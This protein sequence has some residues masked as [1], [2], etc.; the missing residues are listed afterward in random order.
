MPKDGKDKIEIIIKNPLS[1]TN[2]MFCDCNKLTS[3][4]LSNINTNNVQD[5]SRMFYNCSSLIS[6]NLS[7][8]NTINVNDMNNMFSGCSSLT[9]LN[10][11]D[12][13]LLKEWIH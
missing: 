2:L 4:N 11:R 9:S 10:T 5:M 7:N 3:L 12:K 1:N 6:L 8:F 13:R